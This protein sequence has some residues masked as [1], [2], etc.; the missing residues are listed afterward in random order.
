MYPNLFESWIGDKVLISTYGVLLAV[1]FTFAYLEAIRRALSAQENPKHIERIFLICVVASL[2]G[3]RLFHILFEEF[4]YYRQNPR[5]IL[6]I[7]EG[8][9]VFYGGM[10]TS[11]A[12]IYVYTRLQRLSFLHFL[13]L[14]TPAVLLGLAIGRLGC[15]AAGCCWGKTTSLPWGITFSHPHSLSAIRY[16]PVH[17]VQ[18]YESLGALLVFGGLLRLGRQKSP[19][20]TMFLLGLGSYAGLRFFVEFF[21][22]DEYRGFLMGGRISL[23]QFFSVAILVIVLLYAK[24]RRALRLQAN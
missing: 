20:G 7:W 19:E 1:A 4:A 8:G 13:D 12:G 18:I 21:R 16:V 2:F 3:A 9:F 14:I 24:Y 15:L 6:A 23:A 17:P 10:L 22:G 5:Q 11:L